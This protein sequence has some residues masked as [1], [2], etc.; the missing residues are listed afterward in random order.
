M[1]ER[2]QCDNCP[3]HIRTDLAL[4]WLVVEPLSKTQRYWTKNTEILHFCSWNC[5]AQYANEEAA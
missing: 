3:A 1:S 2:L 5:L 4:S